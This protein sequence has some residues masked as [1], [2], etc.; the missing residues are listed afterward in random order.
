MLLADDWDVAAADPARGGVRKY[1]FRRLEREITRWRGSWQRQLNYRRV[2]LL[3]ETLPGGRT[4]ESIA[5]EASKCRSAEHALLD[6]LEITGDPCVLKIMA[7]LTDRE[8]RIADIYARTNL[9]WAKAAELAGQG[10]QAGDTVYRKLRRL[11]EEH[12]RRA[13]AGSRSRS[14]HDEC[15]HGRP[16]PM[17]SPQPAVHTPVP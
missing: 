8:T 11:G 2:A 5:D 3:S 6:Q 13:R 17:G 10:A 15:P 16:R 9:S 14:G 4:V 7:R 1:F 12:V